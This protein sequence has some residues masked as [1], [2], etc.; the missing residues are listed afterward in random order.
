MTECFSLC[1]LA[2][3]YVQRSDKNGRLFWTAVCGG[4]K[5]TQKP[6]TSDGTLTAEMDDSSGKNRDGFIYVIGT[7]ASPL[8]TRPSSRINHLLAKIKMSKI[9]RMPRDGTAKVLPER[10][11]NSEWTSVYLSILWNELENIY[12]KAILFCLRVAYQSRYESM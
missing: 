9:A 11:H 3:L 5:G 10:F 8:D 2:T 6:I 4:K 12:D 1:S 7:S